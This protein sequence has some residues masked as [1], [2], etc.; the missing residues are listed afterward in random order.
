MSQ[1][2]VDF[3][4]LPLLDLEKTTTNSSHIFE[5]TERPHLSPKRFDKTADPPLPQLKRNKDNRDQNFSH[6]SKDKETKIHEIII[7][8]VITFCGEKLL[9]FALHFYYILW[10]KVITFMA[11]CGESYY[12]LR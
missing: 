11:F 4:R 8:C 12:I 3:F 5:R 10:Q 6:Q 9:H 7:F 2:V 1:L